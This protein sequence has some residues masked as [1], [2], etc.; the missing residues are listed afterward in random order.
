MLL[1]RKAVNLINKTRRKE[2]LMII[3]FC[4]LISHWETY[5]I[6]KEIK[7]NPNGYFI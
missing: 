6:L 7:N 4:F 5:R 3:I 2:Y 1:N